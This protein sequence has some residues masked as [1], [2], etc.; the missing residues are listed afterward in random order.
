MAVTLISNPLGHKLS[1]TLYNATVSN[2][3]GDAL[4]THSSPASNTEWV[5]IDSNIERYSGFKYVV[6][7]TPTTFKI[8]DELGGDEIAFIQDADITFQI[9]TLEHTWQSVQLPIVYTLT[10]TLFPANSVDPQRTVLSFANLNGY[11]YLTV[12]DSL[13]PFEALDFVK[14]VGAASSEVNGVFQIIFRNAGDIFSIDLAYDAGYDFTGATVQL[15]KSNYFV[16][17]DVYSGLESGHRWDSQKPS[18]LVATLRLIPD[19][20]NEI[21]FSISEILK[22]DINTRNNLQLDTLPNNLDFYTQFHIAWYESYDVAD[23]G[24]I[25]VFEGSTT[26]DSFIG[27][28][29]NSMMP[30]KSMNE[31]FMSDYINSISQL[32]RWLIL[33]DRPVAVVGMFFDIS[34]IFNYGNDDLTITIF[35]SLSGSVTETE[36]IQI[37]NP[38]SGVLRIPIVPEHGFD[39]YCIQASIPPSTIIL[40][41]DS[42]TNL[43]TGVDWNLAT[44][45]PDITIGSGQTSKIVGGS[46]AFINGEDYEISASIN[47]TSTALVFTLRIVIMDTS[48][49][50]LTTFTELVSNG[51][52]TVSYQNNYTA[53]ASAAKIGVRVSIAPIFGD[54][55]VEINQVTVTRTGLNVT[56]QIC[57]NIVEECGS[58]FVNDN[59]RI[60]ETDL[61]REL[62]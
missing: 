23:T 2:S 47:Y 16:T 52:D 15:Y 8:R 33:V 35:K 44:S 24:E 43:L 55:D 51:S 37:S 19:A 62:E 29:V 11:T 1:P 45:T 57:I 54:V 49:N 39:L 21:K 6:E 41:I 42:W 59:L 3:S 60:T 26:V 40:N 58:T 17:V 25:V 38:G 27:N 12:S 10:S 30:F 20:D 53:V 28:A 31:S 22:G 34:M 32:A 61:F 9:S 36:I 50:I 56:E 7:V 46:Y 13:G 14:I 4:V 18:Q 5:Y 48:N